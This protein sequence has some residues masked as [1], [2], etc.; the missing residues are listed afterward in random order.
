MRVTALRLEPSANAAIIAIC[1]SFGRTFAIDVISLTRDNVIQFLL[2]VKCFCVTI[3][4]MLKYVAIALLLLPLPSA[5]KDANSSNSNQRADTPQLAA[6]PLNSPNVQD[7]NA[8]PQ[9]SG[10]Q[11]EEAKR[12]A[13]IAK[14]AQSTND[15]I[16][17]ATVVVAVFSGLS[18][19]AACGYIVAALLQ[20]SS[21][22][23]Q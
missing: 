23:K 13:E 17:T 12:Q 19:L 10:S 16:A 14:A 22:K 4:T 2:P 1:L 9:T 11:T 5:Q 21:I 18:F 7:E 8:S 3:S 15:R 6:T 20:W